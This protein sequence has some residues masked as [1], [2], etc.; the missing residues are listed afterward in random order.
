MTE[1]SVVI[2]AHT[3]DR[4]D[5]LKHA[6]G[7]VRTQTRAPPEIVVVVEALSQHLLSRVR[8]WRA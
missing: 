1:A 3:L 7:S 6:V 5:E 2:C 8:V 4:W